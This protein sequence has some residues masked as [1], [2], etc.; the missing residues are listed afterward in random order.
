MTCWHG[1]TPSTRR[2][3]SSCSTPEGS[4]ARCQPNIVELVPRLDADRE[5]E[6]IDDYVSAIDSLG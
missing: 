1:S 4:T 3:P 5:K 2:S 6:I